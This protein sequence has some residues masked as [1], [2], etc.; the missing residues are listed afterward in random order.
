MK[1]L[2]V[3]H[4]LYSIGLDRFF[5]QSIVTLKG[6][7]YSRGLYFGIDKDDVLGLYLMQRGLCALSGVKMEHHEFADAPRGSEPSVDRIDSSGHY[8][9]DN[10]QIVCRAINIMKMAMGQT[11]FIG[12]CQRVASNTRRKEDQLLDEIEGEGPIDSG[13]E[14]QH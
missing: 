11:E 5:Q 7:A 6:G 10:I 3:Q 12:W 9:P 4:E 14:F 1:G 2:Y 8:T 13:P